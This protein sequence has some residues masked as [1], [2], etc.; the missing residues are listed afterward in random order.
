MPAQNGTTEFA[1]WHQ[2]LAS[3]DAAAHDDEDAWTR[4]NAVRVLEERLVRANA[5]RH[6]LREAVRL[7]D[8]IL[9]EQ[10][11]ALAER[12]R[13][14]SRLRALGPHV[15]PEPWTLGR[16]LRGVRRRLGRAYRRLRP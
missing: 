13:E 15:A 10:R 4:R 14:I 7:R 1:L 9:T 16:I 3:A 8:T 2:A 6:A 11:L 5:D 12:D